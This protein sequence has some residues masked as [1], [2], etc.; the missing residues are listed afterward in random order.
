[1]TLDKNSIHRPVTELD[2]IT[3]S[4]FLYSVLAFKYARLHCSVLQSEISNE[5]A[6][7]F[8]VKSSVCIH[9]RMYSGIR[10]KHINFEN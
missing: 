5:R 8:Q 2:D 3:F 7:E 10:C 9:K 1:M 4:L 6:V